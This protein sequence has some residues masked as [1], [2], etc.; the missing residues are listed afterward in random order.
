MPTNNTR[1][2]LARI[3]LVALGTI[4]TSQSSGAAD[5]YTGNKT[6]EIDYAPTIVLDASGSVTTN[7][8]YGAGAV[9]A[10]VGGNLQQSGLRARVDGIIGGYSYTATLPPVAPATIG[11]QQRIQA[12]QGGGGALAGYAWVSPDWTVALYAGVDV[13]NTTL[14][15]N[16]PNNHTQGTSV[17]ARIAGDFYGMLA[18]RVMVSGFGS[19]STNVSTFYT[20][21]KTGYAVWDGV[22]LGPE[23]SA[24]G[25][26]FYSEYRAGLH[27]TGLKLG[28]LSLG[29]S[30]GVTASRLNGAGVYGLLDARIGF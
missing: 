13:I 25:N 18:P 1:H 15:H 29:L 16:D 9:T 11:L 10:A 28:L 5:W 2:S 21:F 14:N 19:Y 7:S 27:M 17:G 3:L 30:G 12:R 20:R 26:S 23:F 24:L 4:F 22:Y 6:S 8:T